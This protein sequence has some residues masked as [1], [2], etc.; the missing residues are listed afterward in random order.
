[1]KLGIL[2]CIWKRHELAAEMMRH[3]LRYAPDAVCVAVGSDGPFSRRVATGAGWLYAEAP[4][5]PR[6]AKWNAGLAVL[7]RAGVDAV[8]ILGTDD[9][10][11]RGLPSL[12]QEW[13]EAGID[14]GGL[15][16]CYVYRA[17]DYRAVRWTGYPEG[18]PRHGETIG[19]GRFYSSA[20]L[21]Q[22]DWR[23]W[24]EGEA[25]TGLDSLSHDRLAAIPNL[26]RAAVRM[27]MDRTLVDVKADQHGVDLGRFEDMAEDAEP[28][29]PAVAW[30][31]MGD[32]STR[33]AVD[34]IALDVPPVMFK[35][36]G[37]ED[38][39][40][41]VTACIIAKNAAAYMANVLRSIEGIA[42]EVVVV[43]DTRT[44]RFDR[45]W[46][47]AEAT[48]ATVTEREW[49][50]FAD[51]RNYATSLAHGRWVLVIDADESF[52][53]S[54]IGGL[55]EMLETAPPDVDG[56]ALRM[57]IGSIQG[58]P[59][60]A[61]SIRLFRRGVGVYRY[62]RHNELTGVTRALPSPARIVTTYRGNGRAKAWAAIDELL[63]WQPEDADGWQH[64][65]YYLAKSWRGVGNYPQSAM[66]AREA[67]K[68]DR[69]NLKGAAAYMELVHATAAN[70]EFHLADRV[71]CDA[72][73]DHPDYAD[74]WHAWLGTVL[75]RWTTAALK[76]SA[77]LTIA[78]VSQPTHAALAPVIARMLRLPVEIR[79]AEEDTPPD[80]PRV[81]SGECPA[82]SAPR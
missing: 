75:L 15:L 52:D 66:W 72:T 32:S 79:I 56:V 45:S 18:S 62:A 41:L 31:A 8:V 38:A 9:F 47:I 48:G 37:P 33:D 21:E 25:R 81:Q 11:G 71:L 60:H 78:Q 26:R 39:P 22:L 29:D 49:T 77:Y 16:D 2:T 63:A 20:L 6:G 74:L 34:R 42:D 5:N 43:M 4:N 23:I 69:L 7:R 46:M 76:P 10:I 12:W 14:Y 1:M 68:I 13:H 19:S 36:Y 55:R 65:A 53:R 28:T 50:G 27:D 51:Q 3:T 17:L 30:A 54:T 44:D 80:A 57:T 58:A 61:H 40:P 64:R 82:L 67:I 73:M 70:G 35:R 24:P 59:L